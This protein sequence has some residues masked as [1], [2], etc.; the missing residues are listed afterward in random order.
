MAI[1]DEFNLPDDLEARF[2]ACLEGS[3][4]TA[5]DFLSCETFLEGRTDHLQR[6][7]A[8][9]H[10]SLTDPS[11]HSASVLAFKQE[12]L[13]LIPAAMNR[14]EERRYGNCAACQT[15]IPKR[16]LEHLPDAERCV[17]CQEQADRRRG[18]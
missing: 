2:L 9:L 18:G 3:S 7:L 4:C 11:R 16:R 13:V 8:K 12:E 10:A 17:P 5:C 15:R 6:K 14:L 1:H